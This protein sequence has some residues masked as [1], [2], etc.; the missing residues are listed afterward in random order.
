MNWDNCLHFENC[1]QCNERQTI[2]GTC[3]KHKSKFRG[4]YI[5]TCLSGEGYLY[6]NRITNNKDIIS[7]EKIW[8]K[9]RKRKKVELEFNRELIFSFI[10]DKKLYAINILS[11]GDDVKKILNTN[12]KKLN[13]INPYTNNKLS[14]FDCMR[15]KTKLQYLY[16]FKHPLIYKFKIRKSSYQELLDIIIPLENHGYFFDLNWFK[17][18]HSNQI[19]NIINET[20]LI[21][22]E[23]NNNISY[24]ISLSSS[25]LSDLVEFY[26]KLL[27]KKN[28][29]I[30][31]K[32]IILLG[33]LA[34]VIEDV[35]KFY[36]DL[37]HE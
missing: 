15:Y 6:P 5:F 19:K 16:D 21:W 36:P 1:I 33:G 4:E 9:K 10:Q 26:K 30:T 31:T 25:T 17:N 20:K 34:Y 37:I 29:N 18:L 23:Y 13:L 24:D 2:N 8:S 27:N 32:I 14:I 3:L 7:F 35:K 12:V 11:F 22:N 28:V